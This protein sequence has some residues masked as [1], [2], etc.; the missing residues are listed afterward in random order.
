MKKYNKY[1]T[2]DGAYTLV[3][4]TDREI[5][6]LYNNL[7]RHGYMPTFSDFPKFRTGGMYGIT[8]EK[9]GWYQIINS[10]TVVRFLIDIK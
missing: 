3:V 9:D 1:D 4:G 8:I 5:R 2:I 6:S 10:D 7:E